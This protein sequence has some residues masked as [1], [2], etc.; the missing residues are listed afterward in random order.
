[1]V[2]LV[3]APSCLNHIIFGNPERSPRSVLRQARN[4]N[5]FAHRIRLFK[6][7]SPH[8]IDL[9][10]FFHVDDIYPA[11]NYRI[12]AK[13]CQHQSGVDL[14]KCTFTL[15]SNVCGEDSHGGTTAHPASK[16]Q[17]IARADGMAVV[18]VGFVCI[19]CVDSSARR[20]QVRFAFEDSA[21]K[22][23]V[24]E[25]M[26]RRFHEYFEMIRTRSKAESGRGAQRHEMRSH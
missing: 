24:F 8:H 20:W 25:G 5:T 11:A 9:S 21:L 22:G 13:A 1:M 18:A 26:K 15:S 3:R 4:L 10:E 12:N 6:E 19:S 14:E 16:M 17:H 2:Q 23:L 7:I